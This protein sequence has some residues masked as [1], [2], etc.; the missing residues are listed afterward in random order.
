MKLRITFKSPDALYYA[1]QYSDF[2]FSA[3]EREELEKLCKR[4]IRYNEYITVEVDTEQET[5]VVVPN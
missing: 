4:W 3:S 2:H 1:M 5:C